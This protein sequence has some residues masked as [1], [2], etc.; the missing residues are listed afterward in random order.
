MIP[1]CYRPHNVGILAIVIQK[2]GRYYFVMNKK[3]IKELS[4]LEMKELKGG[5]ISSQN[6]GSNPEDILNKNTDSTC[7]CTWKDFS[8]IINQNTVS[9]CN[10]VCVK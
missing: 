1:F 3:K 7:R 6:T 10:C 9:G 2:R 5:T 4:S 8:V